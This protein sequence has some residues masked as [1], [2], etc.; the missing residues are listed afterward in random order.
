MIID[1]P[2]IA[3]WVLFLNA[4]IHDNTNLIIPFCTKLKK[5]FFIEKNQLV[6]YIVIYPQAHCH[7]YTTAVCVILFSGRGWNL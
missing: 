6:I 1:L 7:I 4:D 2:N 5:Q 3:I